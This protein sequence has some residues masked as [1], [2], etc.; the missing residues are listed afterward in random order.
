MDDTRSDADLLLA[1]AAGDRSAFEP[2]ARRYGP[3]LV[4]FAARSV[5]WVDANDVVQEALT[6]AFLHAGRYDK[7]WSV[8]TWLFTL[9][10]HAIV[11]RLRVKQR[12]TTP[13]VD[14]R[15]YSPAD[16]AARRDLHGRLW[17]IAADR[18]SPDQC[19]ALWLH[20]VEDLDTHEVAAVMNRSWVWVKTTLSR[21]RRTLAPHVRHLHEP[22]ADQKAQPAGLN[23]VP[24]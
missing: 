6:R 23:E 21:G 9:T 5:G 11:D 16:A 4:R 22:D 1:V 18:L 20:Y 12:Q 13:P 24:V 10:R 8:T 2:I 3:R 19:Q 15:T 7:R 14:A 17:Q